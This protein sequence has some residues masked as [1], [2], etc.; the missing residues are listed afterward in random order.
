VIVRAQGSGPEAQ[1]A[2]GELIR[3]YDKTVVAIVRA[4]GHPRD[5]SAEDLKQDFFVGVLRRGDIRKLDRERG[6]FRNWLHKSVRNFMKNEWERWR[7]TYKGNAVTIMRPFQALH[8]CTPELL[9][10]RQFA[11]D[12][13]LHALQR[14]RDEAHD[15]ER[16]DLMVR[17]LPGPQPELPE[18][19]EIA[20]ALGMPPKRLSVKIHH[21]RE[22]HKRILREVVADTL[23]VDPTDPSSAQA[24]ALEMRRLYRLLREVPPLSVLLE[25]A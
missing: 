12:T 3:R 2:L 24:V 22:K 7:A 9:C 14:H 4:C 18:I 23:D 6:R 1:N 15:Q 25:D 16:F 13:L 10:M 8:G 17:F 20:A 19:A 11:E 21:L 5:V